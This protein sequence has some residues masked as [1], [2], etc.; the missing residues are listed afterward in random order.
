MRAADSSLRGSREGAAGGGMKMAKASSADIDMA[1]TV[2]NYLDAIDRGHMLDALSE[3]SESIEWIDTADCEQYGRLIDGLKKLLDQGSIS[4]VI[5]GM[6]VVCDPANECIDPNA[7]TIEHHPKRIEAEKQ[8][9]ELLAAL[10]L[11][12]DYA[13]RYRDAPST[14]THGMWD[15][16]CRATQRAIAAATGEKA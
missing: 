4:R 6:A 12:S 14:V 7:D 1:M 15:G 2:A 8:R 13:R 11:W 9:D 3:D 16:A 10:K 5:W